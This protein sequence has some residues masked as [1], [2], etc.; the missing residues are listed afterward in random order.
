VSSTC[1]IQCNSG[2]L[3]CTPASIAICQQTVWDFESGTIEGF[4]VL[5]SP[6]AVSGKMVAQ[7]A[8]VASGK[9]ALGIP[10]DASNS[11]S[12]GFQVGPLICANRG[13][14]VAKGMS[15]TAVMLVQP[16]GSPP[17]LSKATYFGIRVVTENNPDG[18]IV[19]FTP[20]AYGQWFKVSTPLPAGDVQLISFA[21]EGVLA[22]DLLTQDWIGAVYVDD[23]TIQ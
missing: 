6:T 7:S 23:V 14:V 16:S 10:I 15:V 5:N 12:R 18:V 4:R 9:Y 17:A 3:A 21:V 13:Q 1:N 19:K 2:Y 8:A 22:T 20:P 11:T